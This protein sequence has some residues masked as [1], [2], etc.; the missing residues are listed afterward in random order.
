MLEALGAYAYRAGIEGHELL[1]AGRFPGES[2][3]APFNMTVLALRASS[4]RNGVS[5]LHGAISRDMFKG[6]WPG[7]NVDEVPIGGITNGTHIHSWLSKP[8]RE[9]LAL[10]GGKNWPTKLQDKPAWENTGTLENDTLVTCHK[11]AKKGLL[12]LV[13]QREQDRWALNGAPERALPP[14]DPDVL[15]IGFARRFAPY[16]RATLLLRTWNASSPW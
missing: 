10:I 8:M 4:Q 5:Q 14:L 7:A 3:D 6:F 1:Q 11:L 9:A 2:G 16:K 13:N 15:T 12:A